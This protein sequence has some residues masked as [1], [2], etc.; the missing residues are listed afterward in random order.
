[1]AKYGPETEAIIDRLKREGDLLRN[2]GAHSVRSVKIELA[3]FDNVFQTIST[4]LAE[5]SSILQRSYS[6]DRE[7][8]EAEKRSQKFDELNRPPEPDPNEAY[9]DKNESVSAEKQNG[10]IR[11]I[12]K[13]LTVG[14]ILGNLRNVAL[15]GAGAFVVY[16]F[17]KGYLEEAMKDPNS[18]FSRIAAEVENFREKIEPTI[19]D[20]QT[21]VTDLGTISI[22][23]INQGIEQFPK[24]LENIKYTMEDLAFMIARIGEAIDKLENLLSSLALSPFIPRRPPS[25]PPGPP[26]PGTP[27]SNRRGGGRGLGFPRIGGKAGLLLGIGTAIIAGFSQLYDLVMGE[28]DP[29]LSGNKTKPQQLDEMS[30]E[31]KERRRREQVK[32][33][34]ERREKIKLQRQKNQLKKLGPDF[35]DP[36]LDSSDGKRITQKVLSEEALEK[37]QE[38]LMQKSGEILTKNIGPIANKI[39]EET[40]ESSL[41]TILKK[42][43]LVSI[44][45]GGVF[46]AQRAL[47]GDYTGAG[48]EFASGV[49]GTVPGAGTAASLTLDAALIARDVENDLN[50]LKAERQFN[51]SVGIR[52][53]LSQRDP[54]LYKEMKEVEARIH[55]RKNIAEQ[56]LAGN[57]VY[58]MNNTPTIAPTTNLVAQGGSVMSNQTVVGG[59]GGGGDS[60]SAYGVT[61]RGVF[62]Y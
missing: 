21:F 26:T 30:G 44:L 43:P 13:A 11:S 19:N 46:A 61:P 33:A 32:Q 59:G 31:E 15:G 60:S 57:I 23:K 39:V 29:T 35:Y 52:L 62:K 28:K 47:A 22:E 16:N 5:Q 8:L 55:S 27:D 48:L 54:Q 50:Q 34:N 20:I 37:S 49:V 24:V 45:A 56:A 4:S 1:M 14:G 12:L 53:P 9:S 40:A 58:V 2:S 42:I 36:S 18:P 41:K 17:F 51:K 10:G 3:K 7:A 6:A 38:K 25:G